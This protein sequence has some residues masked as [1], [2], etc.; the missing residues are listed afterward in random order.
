MQLCLAK[1]PHFI[2]AEESFQNFL[3]F[4]TDT[5]SAYISY[6]HTHTDIHNYKN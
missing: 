4:F 6:T 3:K 1:V 5:V 2:H